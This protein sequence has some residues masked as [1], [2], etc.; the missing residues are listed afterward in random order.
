MN[1]P[2]PARTILLA[3]DKEGIRN[4]VCRLLADNGWNVIAA[5]NGKEAL[6]AAHQHEGPIDLLLSNIDMPEMSGIEL[7]AEIKHLRPE[8]KI[9]FISALPSGTLVL[10]GNWEF[11]PKPFM[12][13]MLKDRIH[14][15]LNPA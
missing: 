9:L 12:P 8:T 4:L 7:A 1:A 6:E 11:L 15:L 2:Q 5:K 13:A 14:T 10:D 3:E